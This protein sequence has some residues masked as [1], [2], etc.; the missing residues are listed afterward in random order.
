M[1]EF[2]EACNR[3]MFNMPSDFKGLTSNKA[4][5]EGKAAL[6]LCE[7]CGPI[8]VNPAGECVS[9]NCTKTG[10]LCHGKEVI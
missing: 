8:Q 4:W 9:K 3:E 2:C 6:V 7:G 5:S 10:Q 1:A